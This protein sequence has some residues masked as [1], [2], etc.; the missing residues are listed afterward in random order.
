MKEV[1]QYKILC[2][3]RCL[4]QLVLNMLGESANT[5]HLDGEAL[6]L[7]ELMAHLEETEDMHL[8]V[9]LVRWKIHAAFW[10]A[11]YDTVM[12]LVCDMEFDKGYCER[13]FLGHSGISPL[14]FHC[15]LSA[16]SM[17]RQTQRSKYKKVGGMF[18]NKIKSWVKKGVSEGWV[19]NVC[20]YSFPHK[21]FLLEPQR[22][23]L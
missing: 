18:T 19:V 13:Y 21:Y 1:N 6:N 20:L 8:R 7:D 11:E 14:Y 10:F 9:L 3:A 5:F 12:T 2:F 23:T 15:A 17:Y 4:W 22:D 16:I